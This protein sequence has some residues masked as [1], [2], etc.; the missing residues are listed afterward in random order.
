[1]WQN[2]RSKSFVFCECIVTNWSI[3]YLKTIFYKFIKYVHIWT[4][5]FQDL[6]IERN[7]HL[8]QLIEKYEL[9]YPTT[10]ISQGIT[11]ISIE[12]CQ[13]SMIEDSYSSL[14]PWHTSNAV[15]LVALKYIYQQHSLHLL[16]TNK[17]TN[18][19]TNQNRAQLQLAKSV[20][21]IFFG[22]IKIIFYISMLTYDNEPN[23]EIQE[24][25]NIACI[26]NSMPQIM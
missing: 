18:K 22:F 7:S 8:K 12:F 25:N 4:L 26:Q 24:Y 15:A 16:P 14:V 20:I 5:V 3:K 17:H 9:L 2:T 21:F 6:I 11:R 23:S 19:Q 1:M 13:H 10:Y